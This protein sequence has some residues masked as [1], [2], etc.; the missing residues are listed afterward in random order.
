MP[1]RQY[2]EQQDRKNT[3]HLNLAP[4]L[5]EL[6]APPISATTNSA[7]SGLENRQPG[8]DDSRPHPSLDPVVAQRLSNSHELMIQPSHLHTSE[9]LQERRPKLAAWEVIQAGN[10]AR[11]Q[12][13]I[14][15]RPGTTDMSSQTAPEWSSVPFELL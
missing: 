11:Q 5:G 13:A 14:Q 8:A 2:L 10:I 9:V 15:V 1:S 4:D 7:P 6:S 12:A 3:E